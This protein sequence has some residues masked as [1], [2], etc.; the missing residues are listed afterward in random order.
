MM[1]SRL[2]LHCEAG[3]NPTKLLSSIP[4]ICDSESPKDSAPQ[5]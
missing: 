3:W 5:E 4:G 2:R 1:A